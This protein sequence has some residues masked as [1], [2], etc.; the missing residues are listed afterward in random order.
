MISSVEDGIL[1]RLVS[2]TVTLRYALL[3]TRLG[4]L[5]SGCICWLTCRP[6][7]MIKLLDNGIAARCGRHN[8]KSSRVYARTRLIETLANKSLLPQLMKR[9]K[10]YTAQRTHRPLSHRHAYSTVSSPRRMLQ[11]PSYSSPSLPFHPSRTSTCR[12][13]SSFLST[14]LDSHPS[15]TLTCPPCPPRESHSAGNTRS[16]TNLW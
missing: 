16:T 11:L 5:L 7:R 9:D 8:L 2:V 10:Q 4:G 3:S 6:S 14:T 1:D 15:R 12:H 13:P